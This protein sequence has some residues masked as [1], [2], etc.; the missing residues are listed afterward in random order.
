MRLLLL[1]LC[2]FQ[3]NAQ[4]AVSQNAAPEVNFSNEVEDL[5]ADN[6]ISA[7]RAAKLLHKATKAGVPGIS[8]KT[9]RL[10]KNKNQ[11]RDLTRKKLR[12]SKWPQPYYFQCRVKDR[13]TKVEYVT[14]ICCL[15]IHEILKIIWDL[16]APD[17]LLS[18]ACLDSKGK[19]HMQ[20]M[21]E[22]LHVEHLLGFGLHGDGVPCNYDRTESVVVISMNLPG[23]KGKNGRMRIPLVVMPD[24]V[25]TENTFDDIHEVFAWSMRHLL[26][27]S[28]PT[29]RHDEQPW[30]KSDLKRRK[31]AGDPLGFH[32]C[33]CQ[34]RADWDWLAK[35][36]HFPFHNVLTGMC[37]LCNI[38]RC[39][40]PQR[41]A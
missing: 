3:R 10:G 25:M 27:D 12:Y 26:V 23:L 14:T 7:R 8:K 36:W 15:L 9:M 41:L 18:E 16:G 1:F 21:R 39:Q 2:M 22:Q 24:Y 5:V 20:W 6:C 29:E 32:A 38:L 31:S 37:W 35:C 28:H 19:E 11:A 17:V 34:A 13:R 4:P 30:K 40:V 33:L